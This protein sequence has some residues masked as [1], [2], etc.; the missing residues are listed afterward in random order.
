V[1]GGVASLSSHMEKEVVWRLS[2]H[3]GGGG[4]ASVVPWRSRWCGVC[5]LSAK[6]SYAAPV[7]D[8]NTLTTEYKAVHTGPLSIVW[9]YVKVSGRARAPASN[10][11]LP[12]LSPMPALSGL[13]PR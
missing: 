3:G 9:G 7:R 10:S 12:G 11:L 1:D 6:A 2:S 13:G 8:A 4:V 5:R